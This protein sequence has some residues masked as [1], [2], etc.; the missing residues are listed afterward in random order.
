MLCGSLK[1]ARARLSEIL[2]SIVLHK[3]CL[4]ELKI[5]DRAK[6]SSFVA[7]N[8]LAWSTARACD[9][10]ALAI[11]QAFLGNDCACS[12]QLSIS[13]SSWKH[14]ISCTCPGWLKIQPPVFETNPDPQLLPLRLPQA[15]VRAF[16]PPARSKFCQWNTMSDESETWKQW[17]QDDAQ[18]F[19]TLECCRRIQE[20]HLG[21]SR[22]C[23]LWASQKDMSITIF[24]APHF[25]AAL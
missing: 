7:K 12:S 14:C 8:Q 11:L 9:Q 10:C 5:V 23:S 18:T 13:L 17:Q 2:Q 1:H 20:L 15:P 22:Y 16:D 6:L 24:E 4:L 21:Y 19:K 3:F 25:S